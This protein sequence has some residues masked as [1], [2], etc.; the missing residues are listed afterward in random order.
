MSKT[1]CTST[2]TYMYVYIYT[3]VFLVL[4]AMNII[5]HNACLVYATGLTTQQKMYCI[6]RVWL[7]PQC[8]TEMMVLSVYRASTYTCPVYPQ[9]ALVGNGI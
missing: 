1:F 2:C 5:I 4:N 9:T 8:L 3:H 6:S 7:C